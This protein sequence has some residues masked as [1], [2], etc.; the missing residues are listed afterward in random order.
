MDGFEK[1]RNDK[2]EAVLQ[3]AL[4]LFIE[5]GF[6]RITV[7]EIA[8]K[9]HVSKVS[10]YNFFE[11]KDNLRRIIVKDIMDESLE[12]TTAIVESEENSIDKIRNYLKNRSFYSDQRKLNFFFDAVESD[13][14][15]R[16]Y[17]D[18]FGASNKQ[19]IVRLIQEGKETGYLTPDISDD[20]I[21][22]YIDIFQNSLL[23]LSKETISNFER[24]PRLVDEINL[25]FLNGL[26][27]RK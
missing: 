7:T 9:A 12:Q 13:P 3:T 8:K 6:D 26:I 18:D 14:A 24:I 16:Q 2:K 27:C 25:L 11:S 10:I 1:R 17:L 23:H 4:E 20:A 21:G 5:H 19:L 22:I 15:L